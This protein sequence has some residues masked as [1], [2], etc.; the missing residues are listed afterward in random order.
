MSAFCSRYPT[1]RYRQIAMVPLAMFL[2]NLCLFIECEKLTN[3][4]PGTGTKIREHFCFFLSS[5]KTILKFTVTKE[6][7]SNSNVSTFL[8]ELVYH[9]LFVCVFGG[10]GGAGVT[11]TVS[12]VLS[13]ICI[14]PPWPRK[15]RK[16]GKI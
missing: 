15:E 12:S 3:C 6:T 7:R 5:R 13:F 16:N 10:G 1:V 4:L 11:H 2:H 14:L 8:C 9:T